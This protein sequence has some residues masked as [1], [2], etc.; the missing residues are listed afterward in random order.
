M[1]QKKRRLN[2]PYFYDLML[3]QVTGLEPTRLMRSLAPKA[4]AVFLRNK[5][6]YRQIFDLTQF[7]HPH[8]QQRIFRQKNKPYFYDLVLV[9]VTGLEPTRPCDH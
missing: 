2:K 6:R 7:R 1:K 4:S 3:V 9:Q 8:T 5:L